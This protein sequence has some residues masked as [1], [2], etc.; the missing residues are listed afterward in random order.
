VTFLY[1]YHGQFENPFH[2]EVQWNVVSTAV[3]QQ[4]KVQV[5]LWCGKVYYSNPTIITY[6]HSRLLV[7]R[8]WL[9]K[10]AYFHLFRPFTDH[11]SQLL[12]AS[13]IPD[14]ISCSDLVRYT[15]SPIYLPPSKTVPYRWVQDSP[16]MFVPAA[17]RS[18]TPLLSF[19]TASITILPSFLLVRTDS[20]PL[21]FSFYSSF[22][23]AIHFTQKMDAARLSETSVS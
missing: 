21:L 5:Y 12:S 4:W 18:S 14:C 8:P 1:N 6:F 15:T 20:Y 11:Q 13:T 2:K 16:G 9:R 19:P 17:A 3:P 22:P 7:W 10:V 23:S